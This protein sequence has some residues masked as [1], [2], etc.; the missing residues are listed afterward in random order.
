MT[1]HLIYTKPRKESLALQKLSEQ[2]LMGYLPMQPI[3]II[4]CGQRQ[5]IQEPIFMRYLFIK[6]DDYFFN[7][8]ACD[9]IAPGSESSSA[10]R[11]KQYA[12]G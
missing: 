6:A 1:W 8:L 12:G 10:D 5:V 11:G 7:A 4:R 2:G 9:S 3:E